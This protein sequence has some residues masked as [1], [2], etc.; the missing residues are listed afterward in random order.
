MGGSVSEGTSK[1]Y[2]FPSTSANYNKCC[3]PLKHDKHYNVAER[4]RKISQ[5]IHDAFPHLSINQLICTVCRKEI[6]SI[7]SKR[8][9]KDLQLSRDRLFTVIYLFIE[10]S[11][12]QSE[13]YIAKSITK[14]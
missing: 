3:N 14:A 11:N 4:L 9:Q 1:K 7:L 8:N 2:N 6:D 13:S 12:L 5:K 10:S